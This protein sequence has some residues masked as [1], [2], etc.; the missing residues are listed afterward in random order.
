V[1]VV[2]SADLL[3]AVGGPDALAA[4]DASQNNASPLLR[5]VQDLANVSAGLGEDGARRFLGNLRDGRTLT[6][7]A[8]RADE[9]VVAMGNNGG[10]QHPSFV[11]RD[12]LHLPTT[13]DDAQL[14]AWVALGGRDGQQE[15]GA[16]TKFGEALFGFA[17]G[18]LSV[19]REAWEATD[20][21]RYC[22][23]RQ[24]RD[25]ARNLAKRQARSRAKAA[26]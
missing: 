2:L 7:P 8:F 26:A 3:E 9:V 16:I 5:A 12:L 10:G 17:R 20:G 23:E 14:M 4:A 6:T 19:E 13:Y 25:V 24:Q 15:V 18:I 22:A 11:L 1:I 21:G